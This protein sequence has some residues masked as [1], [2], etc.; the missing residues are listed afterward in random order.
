M[1]HAEQ[2]V[3]IVTPL[4]HG[5]RRGRGARR[6]AQQFLVHRQRP[7]HSPRRSGCLRRS[8]LPRRVHNSIPR[9]RAVEGPW[10]GRHSF[11]LHQEVLGNEVMVL[12]DLDHGVEQENKQKPNSKSPYL[13][14]QMSERKILQPGGGTHPP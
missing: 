9:R 5:P 1:C 11:F 3:D 7:R 8:V 13:A 12:D 4:L 14:R 10:H 2:T 6:V